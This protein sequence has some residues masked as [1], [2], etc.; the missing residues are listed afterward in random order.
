VRRIHNVDGNHRE[1]VDYLRSIGWGVRSTAAV[2]DDFPDLV[3]ARSGFTALV[4]LKKGRWACERKLTD[5]QQR[6]KDSWPGV[7]IHALSKE[8]AAVQLEAALRAIH[9]VEVR[10]T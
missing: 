10:E 8:D 3:V 2:G 7:C 6:F 9:N 1:T 5:G 4:E